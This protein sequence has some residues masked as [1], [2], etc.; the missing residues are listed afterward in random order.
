MS[1]LR[2]LLWKELLAEWRSK[3]ALATM[4]FFSASAMLI[5]S[6]ALDLAPIDPLDVVPAVMWVTFLF[7]SLLGLN[8]SFAREMEGHSLWGLKLSPIPRS[9]IYL[10]KM[11]GNFLFL[12]VIELIA[13]P[14]IVVLFNVALPW[15][16][17]GVLLLGTLGLSSAGTVFAAMA[18]NTRLRDVLLPL[19]MLPVVV[20]LM[21][22]VVQVTGALLKGR[23]F[24]DY[25]SSLWLIVAFDV[26]FWVTSLLLFDFVLEE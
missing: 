1:G 19:M 7:A 6:F 11:I 13:L 18:V 4:L 21:V 22:G 20:P 24:S 2:A 12:T 5:F 9:S 23:M 15:P 3:E 26:I 14:L 8:R 16:T 17:L 25:A 10:A